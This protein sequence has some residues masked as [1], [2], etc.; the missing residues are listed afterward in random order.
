MSS[1]KKSN[2]KAPAT[3]SVPIGTMR[4]AAGSDFLSTSPSANTATPHSLPRSPI[5]EP[6]GSDCLQISPSSNTVATVSHPRSTMTK[7]AGSTSLPTSPNSTTAATGSV[8]SSPITKE[9]GSGFLFLLLPLGLLVS[10]VLTCLEHLLDTFTTSHQSNAT[11]EIHWIIPPL[12]Y[13]LERNLCRKLCVIH[14]LNMLFWL[15]KKPP[16]YQ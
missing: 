7:P 12:N 10:T 15:R 8:P 3:G 11:K 13:S 2:S 5:T 1:R 9:A 6:A 16:E 4:K 14:H